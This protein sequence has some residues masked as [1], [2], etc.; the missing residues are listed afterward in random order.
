MD[1]VIDMQKEKESRLQSALETIEEVGGGEL[2]CVGDECDYY[3]FNQL[4]ED[5][6]QDIKNAKCDDEIIDIYDDDEILD[7][8]KERRG[9][10]EYTF[11]DYFD[12][13]LDVRYTIAQH[14]EYMGCD[15]ALA[16]GGPNIW[17]STMDK[18]ITLY[19]GFGEPI[20]RSVPYDICDKIN[21]VFEERYELMAENGR[22]KQRCYA[23]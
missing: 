2:Y 10:R 5:F 12:D 8:L 21:D 13:I 22:R 17:L 3:R 15:I 16:L 1:K 11:H 19:W 18:E 23:R 7:W 4:K 14:G 6:W 9:V 20:S